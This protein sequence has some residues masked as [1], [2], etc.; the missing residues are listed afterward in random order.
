MTPEK[1]RAD[2]NAAKHLLNDPTFQGVMDKIRD[3]AVA[4]FLNPASGIDTLAAAHERIRG[5]ETVLAEINS[6]IG[7]I[8]VLDKRERAQD[9][10]ND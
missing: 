3:D 5:I 2:G 10:G 7:A 9:R 8:A 6:R 4:L 1:I